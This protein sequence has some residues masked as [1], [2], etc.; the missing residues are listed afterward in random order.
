MKEEGMKKLIPIML[1]M[2]CVVW[3]GEVV[4]EVKTQVEEKPAEKVLKDNS[5]S[6]SQTSLESILEEKVPKQGDAI[7]NEGVQAPPLPTLTEAKKEDLFFKANKIAEQKT[8]KTQGSMHI[9]WMKTLG[10]FL[11][12]ASLIFIM[13]GWANRKLTGKK[14]KPMFKSRNSAHVDMNPLTV[15]QTI[16]MG[17]KQ[18]IVLMELMG[19]K[20]L[21]G[22]NE[23]NMQVLHD[24]SLIPNQKVNETTLIQAIEK[25]LTSTV[26]DS[27]KVDLEEIGVQ[28]NNIQNQVSDQVKSALKKLRVAQ[29]QYKGLDSLKAK[30]KKSKAFGDELN[31]A[32]NKIDLKQNET[33]KNTLGVF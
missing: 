7:D 22:V 20:I 32:Q 5:L 21:V 28:K 10:A 14:R 19:R 27:E 18:K 29:T 2:F 31:L 26:E 23:S 6:D 25:P 13:A 15:I 33:F 4:S 30:F 17:V 12:V 24:E 16:P 9:P 1:L 11:F 8:V 3:S